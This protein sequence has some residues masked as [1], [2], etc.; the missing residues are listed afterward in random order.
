MADKVFEVTP[1]SRDQ[2]ES[3]PDIGVQWNC[4][5]IAS[6]VR[7]EGDFVVIIDLAKLFSDEESALARQS[8]KPVQAA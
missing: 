6:V 2:M 3:A 7:R 8:G 4:D 5:Y 1:F